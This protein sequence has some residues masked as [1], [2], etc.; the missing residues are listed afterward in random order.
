L[1]RGLV[2]V[3]VGHSAFVLALVYRT[4]LVRLQ[5]LSRSLIEASQDLGAL[6]TLILL[7]PALLTVIMARF[8]GG[9]EEQLGP[10]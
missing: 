5:G 4:I 6:A 3:I 1:A 8:V 2:A 9:D 10:G 7:F